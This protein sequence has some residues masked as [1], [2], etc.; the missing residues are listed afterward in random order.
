MSFVFWDV[1]IKAESFRSTELK[2]FKFDRHTLIF[3]LIEEGTEETWSLSFDSLQ[4]FRTTTEECSVKIL[5]QLPANGGFFKSTESTWLSSLGKGDIHFLDNACHFV[6][7]C[8]DE[9]VEVVA[10]ANSF[11]F[12]KDE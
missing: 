7:C 12:I 5:E 2:E 4:A 3:K 10:G 1:P 11:K 9:I 6:V 8:Y